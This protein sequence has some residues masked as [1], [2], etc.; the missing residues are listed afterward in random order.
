MLALQRSA[1]EH[2]FFVLPSDGLGIVNSPPEG[3]QLGAGGGQVRL[4]CN[5]GGGC[6][7]STPLGLILPGPE[8]GGP[9]RTLLTGELQLQVV[10]AL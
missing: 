10:P 8:G 3:K 9:A 1:L 7:L 2:F 6:G 5:Q 4:R